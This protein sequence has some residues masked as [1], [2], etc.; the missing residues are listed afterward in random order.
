MSQ[1]ARRFV[2]SQGC[3]LHPLLSQEFWIPLAL[4]SAFGCADP[5]PTATLTHHR[6]LRRAGAAL[7]LTP[8]SDLSRSTRPVAVVVNP[9]SLLATTSA[10]AKDPGRGLVEDRGEALVVLQIVEQAFDMAAV[11]RPR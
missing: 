9:L 3:G 7:D 5:R 2:S 6:P 4:A 8:S 1:P 10:S 11:V